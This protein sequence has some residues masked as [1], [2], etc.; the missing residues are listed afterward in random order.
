M[1]T[2]KTKVNKINRVEGV[3][4]IKIFKK[5]INE[6]INYEKP[7]YF[8]F[9]GIK[10]YKTQEEGYVDYKHIPTYLGKTLPDYLILENGLIYNKPSVNLISVS[11]NV[12]R[13]IFDTEDEMNIFLKNFDSDKFLEI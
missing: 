13:K 3:E 7:K 4:C 1:E 8:T 6:F 5:R 12:Y 10:I 9:L 2:I 11:G